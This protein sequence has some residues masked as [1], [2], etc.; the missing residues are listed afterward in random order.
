MVK[1]CVRG[2]FGQFFSSFVSLG[3]TQHQVLELLYLREEMIA[4]CCTK[5]VIFSFH[6]GG[7]KR[8]FKVCKLSGISYS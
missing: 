6:L 7:T 1:K 3:F 8:H 4:M 5:Y 2:S